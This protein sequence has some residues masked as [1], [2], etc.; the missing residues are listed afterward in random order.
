MV[1]QREQLRLFSEENIELDARL[2]AGSFNAKESSMH[3][4]APYVGKLKSG[5][6]R[7][8]IELYFATE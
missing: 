3:Q 6:V 5:M 8:L 4:L 7:V 2:W 1:L